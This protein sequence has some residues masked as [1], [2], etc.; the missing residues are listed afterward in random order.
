[1]AA[2]TDPWAD[3]REQLAHPSP[4][5]LAAS[6]RLGRLLGGARVRT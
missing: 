3:V 6:E 2:P 1:M 4:E 5:A